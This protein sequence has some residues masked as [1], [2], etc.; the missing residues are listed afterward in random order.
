ME[1]TLEI[2]YLKKRIQPVS[3]NVEGNN[4][5]IVRNELQQF[6]AGN[7]QSYNVSTNL[8]GVMK[9]LQLIIEGALMA[10]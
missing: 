6:Q 9:T 2:G 1:I 5:M 8:L 3:L 4:E 7:Q 10:S